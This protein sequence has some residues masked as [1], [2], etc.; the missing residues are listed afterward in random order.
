MASLVIVV[1]DVRQLDFDIDTVNR[2]FSFESNHESN[3]IVV[4]YVFNADCHRRCVN[5]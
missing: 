1:S 5:K 2:G 3:Q 4:V